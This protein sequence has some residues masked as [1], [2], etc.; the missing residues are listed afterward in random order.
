MATGPTPSCRDVPISAY[1]ITGT[2]DVYS[3][4][5]YCSPAMSAY[6]IDCGMSITPTVRPATTSARSE[7]A[8]ILGNQVSTGKMEISSPLTVLSALL[9]VQ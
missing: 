8:L 4:Y 3:P 9:A 6:D 5:L 7:A 1:V 2:T